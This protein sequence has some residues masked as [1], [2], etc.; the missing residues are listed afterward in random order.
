MKLSQIFLL[1]IGIILSSACSG[2]ENK[3]PKQAFA[4][5]KKNPDAYAKQILPKKIE[6]GIYDELTPI[7]LKR[8]VVSKVDARAMVLAICSVSTKNVQ[9]SA[10]TCFLI[11]PLTSKS[12]QIQLLTVKGCDLDIPAFIFRDINHDG[13]DEF[14]FID[15][16][17][18]R[19]EGQY[20]ISSNIA[21][22]GPKT[23]RNGLDL[24][25]KLKNNMTL[26]RKVKDIDRVALQKALDAAVREL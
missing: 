18:S 22:I 9:E 24:Y 2:Q 25:L 14:I 6:Y 15:A 13:K 4:D 7:Q 12:K 19:C 17:N 23:S 1:L 20:W 10:L 21:E 8:A 26:N 5:W 11:D 3:T 16:N